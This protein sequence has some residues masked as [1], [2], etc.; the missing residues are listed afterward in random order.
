MSKERRFSSK[1]KIGS[2]NP[3]PFSLTNYSQWA[4]VLSSTFFSIHFS[5]KAVI[6]VTGIQ[7]DSNHFNESL[8]KEINVTLID[9]R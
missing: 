4:P 5:V 1:W 7:Q 2:E 9:D 6:T 3:S 8:I